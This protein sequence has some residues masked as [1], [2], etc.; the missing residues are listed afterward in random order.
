MRIPKRLFSLGL[1]SQNWSYRQ[2]RAEKVETRRIELIQIHPAGER[3]CSS[4]FPVADV[5]VF[6]SNRIPMLGHASQKFS[7]L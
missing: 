4:P 7:Q 1:N 2:D 5:N 3:R 6:N